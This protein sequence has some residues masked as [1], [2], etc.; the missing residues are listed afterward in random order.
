MNSM[1]LMRLS[2]TWLRG[3]YHHTDFSHIN[4]RREW[5]FRGGRH[6]NGTIATQVYIRNQSETSLRAFLFLRYI[7]FLIRKDSMAECSLLNVQ[8][9]DMYVFSGL[10]HA[11]YVSFTKKT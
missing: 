11:Q 4:S 9:R 6:E 10:R 2:V 3:K 7:A 1:L 8:P 5:K